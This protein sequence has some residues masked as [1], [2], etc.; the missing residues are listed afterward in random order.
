MTTWALVMT[1][2][3]LG[4]LFAR[5]TGRMDRDLSDWLFAV[6]ATCGVIGLLLEIQR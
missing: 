4:A 1:G 3:S 2:F 5:W 6:S